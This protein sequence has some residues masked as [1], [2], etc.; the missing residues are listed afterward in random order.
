MINIYPFPIIISSHHNYCVYVTF[1]KGKKL[2]P[3]YIGSTKISKIKDGYLGSVSSK[4][5]KQT[6]L[7]ESKSHPEL[8]EVIILRSTLTR[9]M[10]LSIEKKIQIINDV[11]KSNL[12]YNMS[13]ASKN[14]FFGMD[15]SG[16]N[17]SMYNRTVSKETRQKISE[18]GKGRVFSAKTNR[19]R[20]LSNT[21]KKRTKKQRENMKKS[22]EN[23]ET[24]V[25]PF[26]GKICDNGN[27]VRWHN[28]NCNLRKQ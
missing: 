24:K 2:P 16:K 19:A 26:C 17:H 25:C 1:Y 6:F 20:A 27:F 18:A 7:N 11:V 9:K 22:H 28:D 23:Y 10:A 5:Y 21:G 13:F 15:N 14:G 4:K 3:F 8:F 12:F